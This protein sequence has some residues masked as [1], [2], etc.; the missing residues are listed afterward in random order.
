MLAVVAGMVAEALL[1]GE[2]HSYWPV[3]LLAPL[4]LWVIWRG[5]GGQRIAIVWALCFFAGGWWLS[6]HPLPEIPDTNVAPAERALVEGCVVSAPRVDPERVQF[7]LAISSGHR[8]QVSVYPRPGEPAPALAYGKHVSVLA[9]VRPPRNF[10]NPGSFDYERYLRRQGIFWLASATGAT[11]TEVWGKECGH[12]ALAMLHRLRNQLLARLGDLFPDDPFT[13]HYLAANLFGEATGLPQEVLEDFRK[14]GVYHTLVISGQHI[15]I[16]AAAILL[17]TS[18][19][20]VPR[21]SR[22]L[23]VVFLCWA[24][25]LISGY[26]VP[27]LRAAT[28]VSLYLAGSLAYRRARPLNLLSAIALLFLVWDPSLLLDAGF[29][30][31]FTA[32]LLIAGIAAPLQQRLFAPWILAARSL[33]DARIDPRLPDAVSEMRV[34]LRLLA[35]TLSLATRLPAALW[36]HGLAAGNWIAA[37]LGSL[38]LISVVV[39]MGLSPLL[40]ELFHRTPLV[41]PLANL[42]IGPV[43]GVLVPVAFLHTA[44][45][46]GPVGWVLAGTAHGLREMMHW[47]AAAGPDPRI[48]GAPWW[49]LLL[50]AVCIVAVIAFCEPMMTRSPR[51]PRPRLRDPGAPRRCRAPLRLTQAVT[52]VAATMAWTLLLL[53]PFAPCTMPGYL[54]LTMLDVGQGEALLVVGPNGKIVLVDTGGLGGFSS[55]SRLDTGEDIVGPYLWTRGIRQLDL[56]VLS[57]YDFDHAGGAPAILRAFQ[58]RELWVPAP[59]G[60]HVLG[61]QVVAVAEEC[62]VPV[63]AKQAGDRAVVDGVEF[64]VLHPAPWT[65]GSRTANENSLVLRLRYAGSTM[66]LTGDLGRQSELRLLADG[67]VPGAEVL[68]VAHHGSRTSTSEAWVTAVRPSIALVSAGWLNQFRHPHPTVVERL[69]RHGA[70][71]WRTDRDGAI[72]IRSNGRVWERAWPLD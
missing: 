17:A 27:A 48:P 47:M 70:A 3:L 72:T 10:G 1:S 39:Q 26:E 33:H 8:M 25:A 57:H 51:M 58:P 19:L 24:Y 15:A 61:Q 35:R 41:G 52:A 67:G 45:P 23:A 12:P 64:A 6:R 7:V 53:H 43:L 18:L 59:P 9:R 30:L 29:Q 13:R 36:Q 56:L 55:T 2:P 34:E 5:S 16:L 66:L 42:I 14:A 38:V 20:P 37:W 21:W 32:V 49:V 60:D 69:H 54:E 22:Y 44:F 62:G 11:S 31:S 4:A 65:S 46:I 68:K 71:V 63:V 50:C 28:G 40:I